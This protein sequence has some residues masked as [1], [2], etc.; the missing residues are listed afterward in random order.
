MPE[1]HHEI[2]YPDGRFFEGEVRHA[3]DMPFLDPDVRGK[4]VLDLATN[5]GFFAFWSEWNGA[6]SVTAVDVGTYEGYDWGP[7]GAPEGIGDLPQQDKF[8]A[9]D[10]HHKNLKSKVKKVVGSVYDINEDYDII[11]NYGLLYHLRHPV[12]ALERCYEH[13]REVMYLSTEVLH[14]LASAERKTPISYSAGGRGGGR[15]MATDFFIPTEACVVVWLHMA[16]W[17]YIFVQRPGTEGGQTRQRFI[18]C[19]TPIAAERARKN[20]NF[21]EADDAYWS[22]VPGQ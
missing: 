12:L 1:F 4:T 11:F 7:R 10:V 20:K 15:V 6:K 14:K 5:D 13:C 16:G 8:S 21:H 2:T 19:K 17:N 22:E 9:F 3:P 18:C